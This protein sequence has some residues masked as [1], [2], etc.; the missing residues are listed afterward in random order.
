MC[1]SEKLLLLN[2]QVSEC[3]IPTSIKRLYLIL[4]VVNIVSS[5]ALKKSV[6]LCIPM[7]TYKV[8]KTAYGKKLTNNEV[9]GIKGLKLCLLAETNTANCWMTGSA[10]PLER[11][12]ALMLESLG[13]SF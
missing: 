8:E 5:T 4:D 2:N 3:L 9:Y 10:L 6:S 13:A 7:N 11:S 12:K 1:D